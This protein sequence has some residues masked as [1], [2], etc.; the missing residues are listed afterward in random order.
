MYQGFVCFQ[1]WLLKPELCWYGWSWIHRADFASS[2]SFKYTSICKTP[3]PHFAQRNHTTMH[4]R[5][6][7]QRDTLTFEA[8]GS[9]SLCRCRAELKWLFGGCPSW[10]WMEDGAWTR[11]GKG[12]R[13]G[14]GWWQMVRKGRGTAF[15][16]TVL[17]SF[18]WYPIATTPRFPP[19]K[20]LPC[21]SPFVKMSPIYIHMW[22]IK[23]STQPSIQAFPTKSSF[24][25][26][27]C[28]CL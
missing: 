18:S 16:G 14:V 25:S 21:S 9:T 26:L 8:A 19:R 6:L 11:D 27:I 4:T 12:R 23:L 7:G 15:N 5:R 13:W 10:Q 24:F 2:K 1:G 3:Q 28:Y 20:H 22:V 17:V